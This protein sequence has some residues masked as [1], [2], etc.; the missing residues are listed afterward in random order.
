MGW[1]CYQSRCLVSKT[2]LAEISSQASVDSLVGGSGNYIGV[3]GIEEERTSLKCFDNRAESCNRCPGKDCISSD[4]KGDVTR[5]LDSIEMQ[6]N[7]Q[8][9]KE[10][11]MKQKTWA[12][13]R[14]SRQV[15]QSKN[16]TSRAGGLRARRFD[17]ERD[18]GR[19]VEALP[20]SPVLHSRAL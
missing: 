18:L 7:Q 4:K 14:R 6:G 9:R 16:N 1:V 20:D 12:G 8:R 10:V 3:S 15:T 13:E 2:P 5:N 17:L 11:G 19:F